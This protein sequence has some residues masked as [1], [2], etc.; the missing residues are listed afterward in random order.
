MADRAGTVFAGR[1]TWGPLGWGSCV[2]VSQSQREKNR[3]CW[4]HGGMWGSGDCLVFIGAD[5]KG[6]LRHL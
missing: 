4:S 6:I 2:E 5:F 1:E 3:H